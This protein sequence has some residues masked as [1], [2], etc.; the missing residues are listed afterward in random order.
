MSPAVS[1]TKRQLVSGTIQIF[2]AE[3]LL[4]PTGIITSGFLTRNLGPE[5]YGLFTLVASLMS[6]IGWTVTSAFTRTT[7]KFVGEAEDWR[8]IGTKVLQLHLLAGCGFTTLIWLLADP[9]AAF[10][11]EPA[12][13][14]YLRLF[15]LDIPLFCLGYV[16]RSILVG[17]GGF[18]QRAITTAGRWI[19]RL[20]LI[21]AL[22]AM[23]LSIEG[24]ILGSL[25]AS[26]VELLL[27]RFYIRPTLFSPSSFPIGKL[28]GYAVPLFMLSMSLRLYEKLDLFALQIFGGTAAQVGFYGAAQN[29]ALIPGMFTLAFS[30]L[31]LSTL[32]RTLFKEDLA[33]AKNM[34]REAMRA[35]LLMIPF[36][37]L[38]AGSAT[39]IVTLIFGNTFLETAS[40]LSVLIFGA[41]SLAMISVTTSILTAAGKPNWTFALVGPLVPIA[42]VGH[43]V[44]IPRIGSIGAAWV[45][46]AVATLG[47]LATVYAV[48]VYWKIIPSFSTLLRS[49][50]L[51]L[52]FYTLASSWSSEGILLLLQLSVL[53]ALIPLG[54]LTLGEFNSHELGIAQRKFSAVAEFIFGRGW[55]N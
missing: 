29:L 42:I 55:S 4:L 27:S 17:T 40:F 14:N 50:G 25:G 41:I 5:G 51:S 15:S 38:M 31:L 44:L 39:Q 35:I 11:N 2:L 6:W 24:A 16:H 30:P 34:S 49:V 33:A 28:W 20:L 46:S 19:A 32:T 21:V 10:L 53:A 26:L 45:S 1:H 9:I 36:A 8:P 43:W 48:Y 12:T 52:I 13:A 18:T 23:G 47:A 54:F 3:A 37:S 7:I 22:V